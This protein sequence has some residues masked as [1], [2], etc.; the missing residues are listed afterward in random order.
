MRFTKALALVGALLLIGCGTTAPR[1]EAPATLDLPGFALHTLDNGLRVALVEN[2]AHPI[3]G[4]TAYVTTGGRTESEHFAG[5]LHYIEHLVFKGGTRRFPPTAFRKRIAAL[6]DE[7]GGWT[8]D[9]EIQFGFEVP[10]HNFTEALD[11]FA[12]SLLELEWNE[13]WFED[14]RKVVLQE[15][16]KVAER[17]WHRLWNAWDALAYT[18]HPYRRAVIGDAATVKAQTM[19][20]LETYYRERFTPNHLL[21]VLVGDFDRSAMMAE[22]RDRFG[23]YRRGPASFELADVSEP[24]QTAP[25]RQALVEKGITNGRFLMGFR[26]PGA[27]HPDTPGLLVLARVLQ[28]AAEGFPGWLTR[29]KQW[30]TSIN[31]EHTFM[32]DYGQLTVSGETDPKY[33]KAVTGW[34]EGHLSGLG[35]RAFEPGAVAQAARD[36]LTER[37]RAWESFGEQAQGLGFWIDRMGPEAAQLATA[38][39]LAQTPDS[40]A[41]LARKYL[42]PET[43]VSITQ[44]PPGAAT[45]TPVR[46]GDRKPSAPSHDLQAP[47]LLEPAAGAP[48]GFRQ[49]G[50]RGNLTRFEYDNG[51]T[52]IVRHTEANGLLWVAVHIA[53]G[54]WIEPAD[55]AGLAMLT[56]RLLTSGTR[57][58]TVG[59][60]EQVLSERALSVESELH[61]D[62][63]NV[64]RNVHARDG[65]TLVLG[66]TAAQSEVLI[67]LAG[68]ALFRPVFPGGEVDKARK[69]QLTEIASISEDNLEFIKQAFYGQAFAGHPYGRP[70][71]GTAKTVGAL[72]R[73]DV[74]AFHASSYR[75]DR[76]TVAVSGNADPQA[77]AGL[78]AQRWA[79]APAVKAGPLPLIREAAPPQTGTAPTELVRGKDQWCVNMGSATL[80]AASPRFAAAEV[81]L[82]VAR[83]RHFYKYVYE[84][85]TSYRSWIKLWPHRGPSL[86]LLEND[87]AR[88]GF[89]KTVNMMRD[90]LR[91]YGHGV[92]TAADIELA[93]TRLL[94]RVTLAGQSGRMM[95]FE[96]SRTGVLGLAFDHPLRR[97]EALRGVTK[98]AVNGLAREMFGGGRFEV[99]SR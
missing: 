86:W 6:G 74:S 72:T 66:G 99:I 65:S 15:I 29:N 71:I 77:I 82:A 62:R 24:D 60:W 12:E 28:S 52:L 4:L 51:L 91:L 79:D 35:K 1:G 54:Q 18:R 5:A 30:V 37:A 42:T 89:D 9:D 48:L 85:G 88:K 2:H 26:T 56:N 31:A 55:K 59:Q 11:I 19:A 14:E 34:L 8:W 76:I 58:L 20:E 17:P 49:T 32:V 75:P 36:L 94:N 46:I 73:D 33:L 96:L 47:G 43:V 80:S 69:V 63:A 84:L 22:I 68:E 97:V 95:A 13:Q 3:V 70:T 64:P 67:G 7:N 39:I 90:D 98:E 81:L 38:R 53:G 21:L 78:I 40:L 83:G 61:D 41:A 10:R 57:Q 50:Q 44:A 92:F 25:R 93:R 23:D 45:D 16:E 87:V 27:A